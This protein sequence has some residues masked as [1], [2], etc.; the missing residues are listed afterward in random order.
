[1]LT[2]VANGNPY[3]IRVANFS[4]GGYETGAGDAGVPQQPC[5]PEGLPLVDDFQQLTNANVMPVVASGNGGCTTGVSWPAC[6]ST[7][8][9]V[10]AVY[11]APL[12]TLDYKDAQQCNGTNGCADVVHTAGGVACFTDSGDK[13]DVWGPTCATSTPL[14]GGGYD[15]NYFCGTSASAPY[16]AGLAALLAQAS[17]ST[18]A[19]NARLAIRNTGTPIT[20]TRNNI[21]RNLVQANQAVAALS[22]PPPAAPALL[23]ANKTSFCSGEQV[24]IGWSAVSS[25]SGYTV[26]SATDPSFASP[27]SV[28]TTFTSFTFSSSQAVSVTFYY[29]VRAN[30]GC[31]ASST[32]SNTAQVGYTQQCSRTYTYYLSGIART[33]GV[34]P[35]FWHSDVSILNPSP[36]QP[37][38]V[39]LTFYGVGSFPPAITTTVGARQEMTW[40]DVL[41][42]LFA[43]AQD[44]GMIVVQSTIPVQALS[45]TYSQVVNGTTIDTFG[46]GYVGVPASQALTST[47]TG[48]FGGLRSD[49]AFRTNLE[50]VNPSAIDASVEIAFFTGSGAPLTTTT[51]TVP[52]Y[53]WKQIVQAL[54]PGT[55]DA[56]AVVRVLTTDAVILGSASVIDGNSTD[57]TTIAM[58]V[59]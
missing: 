20:D 58:W 56:F 53:R 16:V 12:G 7:S 36:V 2:S 48:F 30:V 46:Q 17:P 29:R 41:N 31:G 34:A 50:F 13:L 8:L 45:R 55:P 42:T 1:M 54:P 59:P 26:Q 47:A 24:V 28:D 37:A 4:L 15:G 33:P 21:T 14:K 10:G 51:T 3:N 22:C 40:R 52:A 57:P 35:A 11:A 38:D 23:S 43:T 39:Q 6:I 32:W 25:V 27:V 44:K 49:G 19:A 5:D 18:S 9:A